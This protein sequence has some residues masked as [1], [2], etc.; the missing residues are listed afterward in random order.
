[1]EDMP[2]RPREK[3]ES[4]IYH[5]IMRGTNRQEIFHEDEDY[6]KFLEILGKYNQK[7]NLNILGWCLMSNHIHMLLKEGNEDLSNTMKRIGV[8][9]A[10]Y[11]NQKYKCTG[12]LFQDRFRSERVDTDEYLLCVIRYI[13]RNPVKAGIVK[14]CSDWKWSS[15]LGYYGQNCYPAELLNKE[16]I[17]GLL[18][19]KDENAV[20]LFK[21]FNETDSDDICLEDAK[22]ISLTD[23]EAK[24]EIGKII[25]LNEIGIIKSMPKQERDETIK[26]IRKIAGLTQ[27]Q[28][29]RILGISQ[30]LI[31]N[32]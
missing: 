11:Y 4:G 2:R 18:S 24:V 7:S 29:S 16:V 6:Q 21:G 31:C 10:W 19:E 28:A 27:R 30:S 32:A 20:K 12:H 26:Q 8:S 3:G 13:H 15:Y 14:K 22:K 5:V 9:F 17:L 25:S 1:V 23:E